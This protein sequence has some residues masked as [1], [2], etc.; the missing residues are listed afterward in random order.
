MIKRRSYNC[1]DGLAADG[2]LDAGLLFVSDQND[3]QHFI[4]LQNRL[5]QYDLLNEYIRHIGSAVFVV[6]P[7][8]EEGRY[9]GDAL[10]A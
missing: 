5:G 6:P 1:T 9:I 7:G 10:F 2:V 3:P 4:R 8:P